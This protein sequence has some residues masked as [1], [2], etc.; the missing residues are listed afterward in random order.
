MFQLMDPEDGTLFTDHVEIHV[1]ELGKLDKPELQET[2]VLEKWLL[3]LKGDRLMK[4][5]LALESPT[6]KEA[7]EE[8]RRLSDDPATRRIAE[9]RDA[10]LRGQLQREFDREKIGMAIGKKE[11][12]ELGTIKRNQEIVQSMHS[13]QIPPEMIAKLVGIDLDTV[14]TMIAGN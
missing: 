7:F 6:M 2:D 12:I 9:Y 13:Q 1:L 5:T 14:L 10:Q 8:I 11:G 4:E 3:F